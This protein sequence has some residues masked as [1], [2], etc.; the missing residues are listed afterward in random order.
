[1]FAGGGLDYI[2]GEASFFGNT[3]GASGDGYNWAVGGTYRVSE[4]IT[5]EAQFRRI[6]ADLSTDFGDAGLQT[7]QITLGLRLAL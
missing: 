4:N 7:D 5:A 1:M 3:I 6:D 2:D